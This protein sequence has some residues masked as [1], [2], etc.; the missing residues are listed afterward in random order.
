MSI[1]NNII[2]DYVVVV[3]VE[4]TCWKTEPPPGQM[5]EIIEIGVCPLNLE[6]LI[7][8]DKQSVLVKPERSKVSAFCTRLTSLTQ[9]QVDDGVSFDEACRQVQ[10]TFGTTNRLWASWG[11]YDQRIFSS[12]CEL[13]G[14][15]YPFSG[16]HLNIKALFAEAKGLTRTVGLQRAI[17]NI[18]LVAEG[19]PH[20]GDDDAWNT[21]RVLAHLLQIYGHDLLQPYW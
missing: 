21:A 10:R 13:T 15:P 11:N 17:K 18:G 9:E 6:T 4:A 5:N 1:L 12:Q 20:R 2:Q 19:R 14:L 16:N 8:A 7:P 3:D